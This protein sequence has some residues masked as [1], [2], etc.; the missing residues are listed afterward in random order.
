MSSSNNIF[1]SSNNNS[2]NTFLLLSIY[3]K[4]TCDGSNFND[5]IRNL[6]MALRFEDK[7]Y[8]LDK[9]LDEIDESKSTLKEIDEHKAHVKDTTKV[10]CIMVATMTPELQRF[11]KDYWPYEMC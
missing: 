10:S 11:Y 9:E 6:R 7:D 1:V 8:D 4:V 5:W 3:A 2:S